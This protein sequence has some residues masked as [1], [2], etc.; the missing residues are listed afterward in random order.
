VSIGALLRNQ[1]AA[2][3]AV[4]AWLLAVEG[5]IGDLL[6]RSAVLRWLPAAAGRALV[7]VESAGDTL[8]LPAAAVVFTA[9]VAVFAVAGIRFTIKRD[10]S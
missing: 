1:T 8:A 2:V 10:I 3:G 7:Q 4:L 9:Y 5:L 6:G